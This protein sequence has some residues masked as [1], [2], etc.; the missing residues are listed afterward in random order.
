[1]RI[2]FVSQSLPVHNK[3][4]GET[5][6][7]GNQVL[8]LAKMGHEV[9]VVC[10][11]STDQPASLIP[12]LEKALGTHVDDLFR[13][14]HGFR[15]KAERFLRKKI[16]GTS[17]YEASYSR[18]MARMVRERAAKIRPDVL[19]LDSYQMGMYARGLEK[20]PTLWFV[21]DNHALLWERA[22]KPNAPVI[23]DVESFERRIVP[24]V[25]VMFCVADADQARF[26]KTNPGMDIRVA[27]NGVDAEKLPPIVGWSAERRCG[28]V[29]VGNMSSSH[30][31]AAALHYIEN[32]HPLVRREV[33]DAT[34][35]AVGPN[36]PPKLLAHAG[37][38]VNVTGFV[39]DVRTYFARSAVFAGSMTEGCGML[40][41][42]Q[43]A[44]CLRVPIVSTS[45]G[46]DGLGLKHQEHALIAN[47]PESF[48]RHVVGILKSE[49]P[50]DA[51]LDRA[52][53]LMLRE[54]SWEGHARK[55]TAAYED[56]RS[57]R[58]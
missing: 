47:D 45:L 50:P 48:A 33:P 51:M 5:I 9:H 58:T 4:S 32:I 37:P 21:A 25:D 31:A 24:H 16:L 42:L 3:P 34:F 26:L 44:A 30:N 1:M 22:G 11:R 55:L 49:A 6:R 27:A 12:E 52:R 14:K 23:R 39:D 46:A 36:A 57:R 2:L 43:E 20:L 38:H 18:E 54:F 10:F 15:T 29:F 13:E 7:I 56:A 8:A 53:D 40:N 17:G 41:K 19:H 28:V 35:Y